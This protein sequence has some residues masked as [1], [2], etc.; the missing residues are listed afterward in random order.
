MAKAGWHVINMDSR[1][2]GESDWCPQTN[3]EIEAFVGDLKVVLDTLNSKPV[4][5]GASKGGIVALATACM[6]ESLLRGIV[7]VDVTPRLE[8]AGVGRILDFM[9]S[10]ADG[11]ESLE[12]AA[13]TIASYTK[14]KRTS[15]LEGLRK[16]LREREDG[17]FIWHWDPH[18]IGGEFQAKIQQRCMQLLDESVKVTIPTLL[19][20]GAQSDVVSHEGVE[21]FRNAVKHAEYID[22]QE[23]SH[24][25][26]GDQNTV[27]SDAVID[28]IGR[29]D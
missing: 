16:N 3:Y 22:V 2:H 8:P 1:G 28:F 10:R 21:E 19:V 26:A 4:V 5:V 9:R 15:N 13:D 17:R 7:L 14:R 29:L 27:F 25:V 11:F 24:M 23:A 18:L 20:R 12:D 6:D